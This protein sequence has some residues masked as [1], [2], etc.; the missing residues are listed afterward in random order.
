MCSPGDSILGEIFESQSGFKFK[1]IL[2]TLKTSY[3]SNELVSFSRLTFYKITKSSR[4]YKKYQMTTKPSRDVKVKE[5]PSMLRYFQITVPKF[6][7]LRKLLFSRF[8]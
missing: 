1:K 8:V 6:L 7:H 5:K 3:L 2:H 4:M